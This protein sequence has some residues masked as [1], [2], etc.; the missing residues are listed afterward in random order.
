MKHFY[1]IALAIFS[2]LTS[3]S[4]TN[5]VIVDGGKWSD[6]N[7]WSLG[8]EPVA[9]ET[10]RV[11]RNTRL[12]V[13]KNVVITP[14]NLTINIW[15][16]L[17]FQVGKLRL[18]ALSTV[19][20]FSDGTIISNQGSSSDRIEINNELRYSGSQG[21][22]SGPMALSAGPSFTI[23]PVKFVA[24]SVSGTSNGVVVKWSTSEESNA[25]QYIIERSEDGRVWQPVGYVTA[26]GNSSSLNNYSYTD[27]G[28]SAVLNYYRV[29]QV[30]KDGRFIYTST[31]SIRNDSIHYT[32]VKVSS[33][34]NNVVVA[35]TKQIKGNV[36]IRLVS[37]SGQVISQQTY[38]EPSGHI[39]FNQ[40]AA[41]G[42]YIVSI[43]NGQDVNLAKQVVL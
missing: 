27:R 40:R 20:V 32:D 17:D 7:T 19:N 26:V 3:H 6:N 10:V 5:E 18:G 13:D 23:L 37:L 15:G 14:G 4:Q 34:S 28:A 12:I 2:L 9:G 41:K 22:L 16:I 36:T 8:R 43:S 30:D 25:S 24:Y 1:L 21:T 39:V 31:K 29:K 42:N 35:F 38:N 33:N 11:P